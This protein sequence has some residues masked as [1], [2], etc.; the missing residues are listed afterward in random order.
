MIGDKSMTL[1][2]KELRENNKITQTQVAS[3]LNLTQQT[4]SLYERGGLV[5]SLIVLKKLAYLY[6]TSVD[7][8]LGL[9]DIKEQKWNKENLESEETLEDNKVKIK[10]LNDTIVK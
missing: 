9:T 5:P 3:Y 7:Y 10:I 2:L 6:D 1:R 8:L 4:Y